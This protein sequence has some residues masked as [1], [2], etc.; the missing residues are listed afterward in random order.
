MTTFPIY[1]FRS[2]SH[3]WQYVLTVISNVGA[4]RLAQL[5]SVPG[6]EVQACERHLTRFLEKRDGALDEFIALHGIVELDRTA[7]DATKMRLGNSI[8]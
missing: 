4:A 7:W 2:Q 5:E 8:Y 3:G 1:G 6:L